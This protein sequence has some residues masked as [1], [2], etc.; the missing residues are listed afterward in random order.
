MVAVGNIVRAANR[1]LTAVRHAN[2]AL[3]GIVSHH[4]QPSARS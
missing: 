4:P 1:V 3:T 2:A